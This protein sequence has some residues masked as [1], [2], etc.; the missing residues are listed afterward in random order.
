MPKVV[1]VIE[2]ETRR[3]LGNASDDPIRCVMQYHTLAGD[4]LAEYDPC[5]PSELRDKLRGVLSMI[6]NYNED[7]SDAFRTVK[8][9]AREAFDAT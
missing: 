1:Q 5:P 7:E 8:R 4:L 6:A 3:G 9:A 2:S